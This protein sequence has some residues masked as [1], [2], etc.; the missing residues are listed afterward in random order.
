MNQNRTR[1]CFQMATNYS[2]AIFTGRAHIVKETENAIK[3]Y[4]MYSLDRSEFEK[5]KLP[6][7]TYEQENLR[8][9]PKNSTNNS[10]WDTVPM[11]KWEKS[12]KSKNSTSVIDRIQIPVGFGNRCPCADNFDGVFFE[13]FFQNLILIH[14]WTD[15]RKQTTADRIGRKMHNNGK[16]RWILIVL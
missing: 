15:G 3:L 12:K 7:I 10:R 5:K 13:F 6:K 14:N 11:Q 16:N 8:K 4:W 1:C 9:L 2:C